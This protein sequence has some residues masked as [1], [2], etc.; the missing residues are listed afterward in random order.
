MVSNNI[1]NCVFQFDT[2]VYC[3]E[4]SSIDIMNV[5]GPVNIQDHNQYK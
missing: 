2:S 4:D 1:T 3:I 5:N